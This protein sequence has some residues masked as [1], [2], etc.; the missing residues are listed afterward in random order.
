MSK[1]DT[2]SA[3][4]ART[5]EVDGKKFLACQVALQLADELGVPPKTIGQICNDAKIKISGCQ[6]GCFK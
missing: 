1:N 2:V 6:L 4:L 5:N 3:V